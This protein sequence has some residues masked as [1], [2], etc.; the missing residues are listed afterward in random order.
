MP[1]GRKYPCN[2][3]I[4]SF[5]NASFYDGPIENSDSDSNGQVSPECELP[6]L[7]VHVQEEEAE[8]EGDGEADRGQQHPETFEPQPE[9][10][11]LPQVIEPPSK[12]TCLDLSETHPFSTSSSSVS[13]TH[14]TLPTTPYV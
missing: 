2:Y 8:F 11:T 1:R 3:N 7:R 13:Y 6:Q 9:D 4:P 14:L 5:L 12:R 10:E